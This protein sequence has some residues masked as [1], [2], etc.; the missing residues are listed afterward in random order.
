MRSK[1]YIENRER[2]FEIYGVSPKDR[3]YNCHHIIPKHEGGGDGKENLAPILKK[4]HE[5]IHEKMGDFTPPRK[6]RRRG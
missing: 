6:R 1:E 5:W 4:D 3:R 2:V